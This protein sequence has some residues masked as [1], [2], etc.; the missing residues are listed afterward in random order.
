[1]FVHKFLNLAKSS[2]TFPC[3][4]ASSAEDF[5]GQFDRHLQ[6]PCMLLYAKRKSSAA[7]LFGVRWSDLLGTPHFIIQE[8]DLT[9]NADQF[10]AIFRQ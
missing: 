1:M 10:L 5:V 2:I 4:F 9:N 6:T 7:P 3:F 8:I